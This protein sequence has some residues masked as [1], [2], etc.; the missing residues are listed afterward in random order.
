MHTNVSVV[1]TAKLR[2][3]GESWGML[4][5][6]YNHGYGGFLLSQCLSC[7]SKQYYSL[8]TH[9]TTE[10]MWLCLLQQQGNTVSLSVNSL[11][12]HRGP[13]KSLHYAV[14]SVRFRR[15]LL[16][17]CE[18]C[19]QW[20]CCTQAVKGKLEASSP[21]QSYIGLCCSLCWRVE[22]S[23]GCLGEFG[24]GSSSWAAFLLLPVSLLLACRANA[25]L[26]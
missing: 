19:K 2:G 26:Y 21:W 10:S 7:L 1:A 22:L 11:L 16:V 15:E 4:F 13:W 17:P 5:P 6:C 3:K 18:G 14:T 25:R 12:W 24:I 23:G 20:Q 8:R 9:L